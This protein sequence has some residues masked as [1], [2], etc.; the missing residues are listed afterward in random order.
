[1]FGSIRPAKQQL[2]IC[3][4]EAYHAM[5]LKLQRAVKKEYGFTNKSLLNSDFTLFALLESAFGEQGEG[6]GD[7]VD[8]TAAAAVLLSRFA[9]AS[10]DKR[11][12]RLKL[13]LT[14]RGYL[15]AQG[16]YPKLAKHI[17][18]YFKAQ[19]ELTEANCKSIDRA[20]EPLA[21]IMGE[22]LS[23]LS[24]DRE[25]KAHLRRTGYFL[26]RF[27]YIMNAFESVFDDYKK[28]GFN[29]L[30]IGNAV[31]NELNFDGVMKKTE[32]SVNFTLG[33]LADAYVQLKF[34]RYKP[35]IDNIINLGLKQSFYESA[36]R[37]EE[38]GIRN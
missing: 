12:V 22:V 8:F 16:I 27:I 30:V 4:D 20:S 25:V 15:A 29:P 1:L 21:E 24:G 11:F 37:R 38:L 32:H 3:D 19:A 14:E 33:A 17:A 7:K 34:E 2:R 36:A 6:H 5:F 23:Y 28:G 13:K 18:L 31:V 35:L 26:G 10:D 9:L